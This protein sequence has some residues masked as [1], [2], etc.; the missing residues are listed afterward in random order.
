MPRV[1]KK[2]FL[3]DEIPHLQEIH[4]R[5]Y[6]LK[7]AKNVHEVELKF[8]GPQ[9]T[10]LVTGLRV[11]INYYN[12]HKAIESDPKLKDRELPEPQKD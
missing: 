6:H 4:D 9:I 7:G 11:I 5:L 3:D 2:H 1:K 10:S 8:T 12:I